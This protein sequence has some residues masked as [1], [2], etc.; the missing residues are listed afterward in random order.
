MELPQDED[1][2][3]AVS[4]IVTR[5]RRVAVFEILVRPTG[6]HRSSN[7]AYGAGLPWV[8]HQKRVAR[9]DARMSLPRMWARSHS[10]PSGISLATEREPDPGRGYPWTLF[11][12]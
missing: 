9:H 3:D 12:D 4:Y 11:R 10:L 8:T 5:L 1:V 7:G 6:H 2:D